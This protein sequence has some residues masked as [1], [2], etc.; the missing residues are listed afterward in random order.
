MA[1]RERRW[2]TPLG[3][4]HG[5]HLGP[6]MLH[7]LPQTSDRSALEPDYGMAQ[8]LKVTAGNPRAG[9]SPPPGARLPPRCAE[10]LFLVLDADQLW[11]IQGMGRHP[12]A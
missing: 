2:D 1:R 7:A 6:S 10:R 3:T 11:M 12:K 4:D 8:R 5:S 9:R